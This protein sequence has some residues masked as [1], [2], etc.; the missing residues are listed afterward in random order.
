M[1]RFVVRPGAPLALLAA[2]A[3]P[4]CT[5]GEGTS[6]GLNGAEN[7][8]GTVFLA[9]RSP[10]GAVMEALYTGK[11][12]RDA[13]GCLRVEGEGGAVVIWPYGFALE[14]RDGGLYVK[15]AEGRTIGQI[16][17]DFRMGGGYVPA[18]STESFLSDADR[19]RAAACPTESYWIVGETG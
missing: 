9:Q 12:N 15:N 17:G 8:D 13:Q 2:L 4:A 18:G 7:P 3:L 14:A 19:A 11:V 10:P 5:P 1:K 6:P 16:G